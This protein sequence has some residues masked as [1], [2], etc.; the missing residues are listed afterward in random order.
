M[1][2]RGNL[3]PFI[4]YFSEAG[5]K[6]GPSK[7]FFN[8]TNQFSKLNPMTKFKL[9]VKKS[10]ASEADQREAGGGEVSK[11]PLTSALLSPLMPPR[12]GGSSTSLSKL[13]SAA[14]IPGMNRHGL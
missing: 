1:K 14:M 3:E 2:S 9:S 12:R 11:N 4:L 7:Q 13:S 6:G 8:M 10:N 5:A